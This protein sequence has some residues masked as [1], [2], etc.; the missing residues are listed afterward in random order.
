MKALIKGLAS[1][2]VIGYVA[3]VGI[4]LFTVCAVL[5]GIYLAFCASILLGI[6]VLLVEPSPLV[7][8]LVMIFFHKNLAQML[9]DFLHK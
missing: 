2:G 8:G 4:F 5:Y 7:I 6:L 9:V 3:I 1:L